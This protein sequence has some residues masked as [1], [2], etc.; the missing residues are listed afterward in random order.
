VSSTIADKADKT[1][2]NPHLLERHALLRDLPT[3]TLTVMLETYIRQNLLRPHTI[4]AYRAKVD[5]LVQFIG[6]D[7]YLSE[8]DET[9]LLE[10]RRHI[11]AKNQP[12]T[13]N[14][15]RRH[16]SVIFN[17]AIRAGWLYESP[18]REVSS[19]PVATKPVRRIGNEA[20]ATTL[21]GIREEKFG[22]W[23]QPS[24][25]WNAFLTL[26]RYTGMRL[27]QVLHLNWGDVNF[28][29]DTILLRA[30]SSKTRREW[31]I[32]L[33]VK[34]RTPL[35]ELRFQC[36]RVSPQAVENH[37]AVFNYSL[38]RGVRTMK[39]RQRMTEWQ[40][41]RFFRGMNKE[42][43]LRMSTH[44]LRHTL[45]S[46]AMRK[47]RNPKVV[48]EILGHTSLNTTMIYVTVELEDMR[49]AIDKE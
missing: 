21:A 10:F 25:F 9:T 47:V 12:S 18:F 11:L 32:P 48:Q 35:L 30:E 17:A 31:T 5:R 3:P 33:S 26:C 40:V 20:L 22:R 29:E 49:D 4:K 34:L 15:I 14:N 16:I 39:P 41:C 36:L 13:F 1:P 37:A 2:V 42:T 7:P 38:F 44:R 46:E 8:I 6:R 19:A 43:G 45:G 27:Q 24:W 23:S 28:R